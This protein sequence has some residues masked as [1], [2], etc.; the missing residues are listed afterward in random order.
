MKKLLSY[1]T[2]ENLY[3]FFLIA[4]VASLPFARIG[5]SVAQFSILG[6]W[7]LEGKFK[8]KIKD[9]F[10]SKAA[11]VL[12][13]F[14]ILHLLGLLYTT[15]FEYGLKDIRIKLPLLF[16]PI[17]F[18]TSAKLRNQNFDLIIKFYIAAVLTATF[19]SLYLRFTT[20]V[21]DFRLLSP[22]ISHIRLSLNVCLALFFAMYLAAVKYS[23]KLAVQLFL[24]GVSAWLLLFLVMIES[25]TGIF[26][27]IV[28]GF[29]LVVYGLVRFRDKR[30]K[31]L[32]IFLVLA[33]PVSSWIYIKYTIH[34]YFTTDNPPI[35]KLDKFTVNGNPYRHD[36]VFQPVENGSWIG[37]YISENELREGWNKRSSF[38]FDGY[39]KKGQELKYT[40]Y[41]Y[42]NS[43]GLRKDSVGMQALS[44]RDIQ[45]VEMGIANY[46]YTHKISLRSRLYKIFWEYQVMQ[47]GLNPGGH[48]VIQR[49]EYW[50]TAAGII[51]HNFI[52]G[53][54]TGDVKQAFIDEYQN[55]NTVLDPRYQHRAHNQYLAIFVAFGII[56]FA[57]F[58]FYLTYPAILQKRFYNYHYFV[59]W[60]TMIVSMLVE[61][62]LETQVGVTLFAFFN[63]FLLFTQDSVK[64]QSG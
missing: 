16:L 43:K 1:I 5:M 2:F 35:E 21:S 12:V 14:Y 24:F 22:F 30:L 44:S 29:L 47:M 63:T 49:I 57:W 10:S 62:G 36:T 25:V 11:L 51:N 39:D 23:G 8:Q 46:V 38:D 13:S 42:L 41:R 28:A 45:Y 33:I 55:S 26:I 9:L 52:F 34:Q 3:L 37:L 59:F 32:A 50:K 40:L 7:F 20:D 6:L 58:V 48:S 18:A 53:V 56:G 4:L 54:G 60:I 15:D 27:L 64:K 19:Y 61:D 17:A 31:L